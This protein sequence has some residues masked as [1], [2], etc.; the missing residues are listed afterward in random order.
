MLELMPNEVEEIFLPYKKD[1]DDLL[2]KI[3]QMM[4][5]KKSIDEILSFT[6]EVILK[7]GFGFSKKEITLANSIWKKLRD[8]RLN[9]KK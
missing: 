4:R 7:K 5:D 3:D 6:N 1:H 8:R 9:R 2:E